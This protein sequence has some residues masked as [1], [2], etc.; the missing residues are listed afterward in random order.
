MN[1]SQGLLLVKTQRMWN[2]PRQLNREI[3][4]HQTSKSQGLLLVKK[5][6]MRNLWQLNTDVLHPLMGLNQGLP[7]L[8][9][10]ETKQSPP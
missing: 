6:R 4:P 2:P 5:L 10:K 3:P 7:L 1:R 9:K 8:K